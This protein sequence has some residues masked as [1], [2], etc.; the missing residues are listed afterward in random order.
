M[1]YKATPKKITPNHGYYLRKQIN[2]LTTNLN[3][4]LTHLQLHINLWKQNTSLILVHQN[5]LHG[6]SLIQEEQDKLSTKST[7]SPPSIFHVNLP[8]F[9]TKELIPYQ[10]WTKST[11]S[12]LKKIISSEINSTLCQVIKKETQDHSSCRPHSNKIFKRKNNFRYQPYSSRKPIKLLQEQQ[13]K[14]NF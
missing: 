10:L 4:F 13:S 3:N 2:N 8:H 6:E 7:I 5:Q 9:S 12:S 11:L 1:L 14:P